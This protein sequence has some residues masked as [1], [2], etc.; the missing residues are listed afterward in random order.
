[1]LNDGRVLF[2]VDTMTVVGPQTFEVW[3]TSE[4]QAR[5]VAEDY[6][7]QVHLAIQIEAVHGAVFH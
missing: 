5:E 4:D 2:L 1:M 7:E 3:A 6:A